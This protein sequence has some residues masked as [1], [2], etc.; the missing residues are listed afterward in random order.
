MLRALLVDD[1]PLSLEGLK[2]LIDWQAEGFEICCECASAREA[3]AKLAHLKPD[4]I[5][6][7][8]RM[9]GLSGLELL[10]E[11]RRSGFD[12][13]FVIVSG[14]SDFNYA[15]N[16]LQIGVAGYLLKPVEPAEAANVLAHVRHKLLDREATAN[17]RGKSIQRA[18]DNLL[19]E[20]DIPADELP[21]AA[22]WVLATWGAPL[23]YPEVQALLALFPPNAGTTHIVEDK[24]YLVLRLDA[25]E[26]IPGMRQAEALL[27]KRQRKL[28]CSEPT[29]AP[30]A[31]PTLRRQLSDQLDRACR[32]VPAGQM[33]GL[34]RSISLR[35]ADE[36]TT[37]CREL[38][39]F[40]A[41][42]GADALTRAR[43]QLLSACSVLLSD[44]PDALKTFLHSQ[45][46]DL[47]TLCLTAIQLLEP[48][49][50]LV[51]DRMERY[52][53]KHSS[54]HITVNSM[55]TV[56]GYNPTYLGRKFNEERSIGFREW[57]SNLRAEQGA[58]LLRDTDQSVTAIA[59]AVGFP[60]YKRFLRHF[61]QRYGVTPEQYRRQK[62]SPESIR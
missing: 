3:L 47:Q 59:R 13:Q 46:S 24:E 52:V 16:A 57:L 31:L 61:K 18:I 30:A 43:R 33:D 34:I 62:A 5:V 29:N 20:C 15:R 39:N 2:L 22:R 53:R 60:H 11:A 4:L 56:M 42:C 28:H 17:R 54:E 38:E 9:P 48:K 1:E 10:R 25:G 44:R 12:G 49:Q 45:T 26:D 27:A 21:A 40:C 23:P 41:A 37:R 35:Q 55:A 36:C 8:I 19:T 7:D 58:R 51:S 32:C 50:E 14:Y 6:T